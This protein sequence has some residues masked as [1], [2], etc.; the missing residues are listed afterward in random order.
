MPMPEPMLTVAHA[1]LMLRRCAELPLLFCLHRNLT[2]ASSA[3]SV[4]DQ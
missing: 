4:P 2:T 1:D 3:F